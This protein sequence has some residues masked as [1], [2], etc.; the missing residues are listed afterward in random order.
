MHALL[1]AVAAAA[2]EPM[3]D[4][5]CDEYSPAVGQASAGQVSG[6]V[7]ETRDHVWICF[8]VPEGSY[9]SVDLRLEAPKLKSALNLHA[10]AQLGEWAADDPAAAPTSAN[11]QGWWNAAGWWASTTPFN[12]SIATPQGRQINF[13]TVRG[14]EFQLSKV[15]FG[16]GTWRLSA[17]LADVRTGPDRNGEARWPA[18]GS[19]RLTVR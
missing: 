10:S 19:Y 8:G 12:G 9:A 7:R 15:R 6:F 3:L 2:I 16:R 4:G 17:A 13:R 5:E 18:A 14:R 1:V 11:G